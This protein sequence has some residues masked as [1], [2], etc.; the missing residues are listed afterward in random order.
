MGRQLLEPIVTL[1]R[2][3]LCHL[4]REPRTRNFLVCFALVV[5]ATSSGCASQSSNAGL[6]QSS[7]DDERSVL[8]QNYEYIASVERAAARRGVS[9]QWVNPLYR[10]LP[11][12]SETPV[13]QTGGG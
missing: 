2:H 6:R 1:S 9:V 13:S 11:A 3:R 10:R 4:S 5:N 12:N 7:N 8:R